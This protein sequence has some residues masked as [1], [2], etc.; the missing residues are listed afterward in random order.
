MSILAINGIKSNV[1]VEGE[2]P[3]LVLLHGFTGSGASW[4]KITQELAPHYT[5]ITI[6][7]LGHGKSSIPL[8]PARYS[9]PYVASD[10]VAVLDALNINQTLLLGYSMGGRMALHIATAAPQRLRG[11]ILESASPGL[12]TNPERVARIQTD[13]QLAQ[14][15][16][17][18]GLEKFIQ[19]WEQLPLFESQQRLPVAIK[20]TQH[21]QRL[22]NNPI[23]L[24][25]SLRGAGTGRQ[26]HLWDKLKALTIPT[27]LIAGQLDTKYFKLAQEML[28]LIPTSTLVGW[29]DC[30]HT[31][32]LENSHT[33]AQAV[34]KF[35]RL[36][37]LDS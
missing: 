27:L 35:L 32:H 30:G 5:V 1:E 12:R 37:K 26:A 10:F 4:N 36:N 19:Y 21:R 7:A 18:E 15:L 8:D 28:D 20:Q 23:G 2:G 9:M 24:A 13:E 17:T 22:Q 16:E 6:D 25:N 14:L 29:K 3:P 11:L 31:V 33:F 34:L